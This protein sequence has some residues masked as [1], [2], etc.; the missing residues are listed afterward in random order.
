M[1]G[2]DS[3]IFIP[4][5]IG[6]IGVAFWLRISR[7]I[8]PIIGKSK[9]VNLIADNSYSIMINQYL[10]F[11]IVNVFFAILSKVITLQPAFNWTKFKSTVQYAYLPNNNQHFA[12]LYLAAG[13]F[14]PILI[15]RIITSLIKH[16]KSRKNPAVN[17]KQ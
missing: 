6:F 10:G 14:L 12:I 1:R 7:I 17:S 2:L 3:P 16:I 4:F 5:F 8:T 15:Q 11:M 13:I 9:I